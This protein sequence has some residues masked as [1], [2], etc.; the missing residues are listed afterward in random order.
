[1][2]GSKIDKE[3]ICDIFFISYHLKQKISEFLKIKLNNYK[4]AFKQ[5]KLSKI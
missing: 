4:K 5:Y 2:Q 1:V 3:S